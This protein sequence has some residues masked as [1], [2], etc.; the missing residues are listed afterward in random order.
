MLLCCWKSYI[1]SLSLKGQSKDQHKRF[2]L[3][4]MTDMIGVI[5]RLYF[6]T[7]NPNRVPI[8]S[9]NEQTVEVNA[10]KTSLVLSV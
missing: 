6:R 2:K 5:D 10:T 4:L 1:N 9:I 8:V 3:Q 7:I